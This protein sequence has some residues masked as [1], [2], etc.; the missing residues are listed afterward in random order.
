M[1]SH[2]LTLTL[3]SVHVSLVGS[4]SPPASKFT[5]GLRTPGAD[6]SRVFPA[7]GGSGICEIGKMHFDTQ[8][9]PD[10]L[11][12]PSTSFYFYSCLSVAE[13]SLEFR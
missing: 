4:T 5:L 8:P 12:R 6:S 1:T 13:V 3:S 9:F 10:C 2:T 11:C 7:P